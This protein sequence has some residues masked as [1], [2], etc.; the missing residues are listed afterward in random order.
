M[1]TVR[2]TAR[3]SENPSVDSAA[4]ARLF[5][6]AFRGLLLDSSQFV[7][8]VHIS[9]WLRSAARGLDFYLCQYMDD[10]EIV[11]AAD[12]IL[13]DLQHLALAVTVLPHQM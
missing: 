6:E 10:I 13:T 12:D 4:Q 9:T 7:Q 11:D 5:A 3:S 2:T 8:C 1:D